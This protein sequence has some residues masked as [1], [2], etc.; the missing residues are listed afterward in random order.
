MKNLLAALVMTTSLFSASAMAEELR[1]GFADP[2]SSI[3]PQLNNHAGDHS[4]AQHFW[5]GLTGKDAINM[6]PGVA[7][8]WRNIDP[9]TWEFTLFD[10][11]V[12]SDGQPVTA[13]DVAFSYDRARDVPGSVASVKGFIRT[14]DK[15]EIKDDH[16]LLVK[17]TVP[18][19]LLPVSL[20]SLYIVSKHV[21]EKSTTED[22]NSGKAMVTN[23]AYSYV[24]YTPGDRVLMKRNETYTGDKP[25]WD[26]VTYR[27]IANPAART[28]A[29]LAKDVDVI[30]KVSVADISKLEKSEGVKVYAYPG[31][32]ALIM[33][34]SFGAQPSKYLTDK[35]GNPLKEN[36]LLNQKV[37]E[38][39]TLAINREAL[40]SRIM[41]G[42]ATVANQW[43]PDGT[44]G[45]DT[46]T[47]DI[48]FDAKKAKELL[49][50]A[51][52]PDGFKMT[53]HAPSDRYPQGP[54]TAQALAQF[55]TRIGVETQV[56][57]VPFSVY[58]G[59][60]NKGEYAMTMIGWGNGTGEGTY[61]MTSI[62]ATPNKEKGVG[63]SNWGHY[64]SAD[65]DKAL[66]EATSEFD[67]A[68]REDIIRGAVKTVMGDVGIMPL[69][70]YKNIWA[71]RDD[72]K[73]VPWNSD[74]TVAM[75]VSKI[76]AD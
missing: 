13:A 1:I 30:D 56:E 19:P 54:E 17:T 66:A 10:N 69:F 68:K 52:Y 58:S 20:S 14:V 25:E 51:G 5:S 18:D 39:L 73:V 26:T 59:S 27:Y 65:L 37:R 22:Y 48:P 50:E 71:S 12:W 46:D 64:S 49:T 61:A 29:L 57:V 32:R 16:H 40:V 38:A 44:F 11:A 76:K 41:Q 62:L 63:A 72:L 74:R 2:L 3:D 24:G 6:Q 21:G 67:N 35:A 55:W 9:L 53:I 23:G 7:K 28:A 33:Q 45:Y 43:M 36:P 34:P 31:L 47:K 42:G 60:A 8:T 75:Q 4:V 70:H 15:V